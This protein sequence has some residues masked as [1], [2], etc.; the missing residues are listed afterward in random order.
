MVL[1]LVKWEIL[2]ITRSTAYARSLAVALLMLGLSI[3]LLS[4][5]VLMGLALEPILVQGLGKED[6]IGFLNSIL[7]Y[8]FLFEIIYR[9]FV[10]GL[11]VV[12]LES[13]LHLPISKSWIIRFLLIRSFI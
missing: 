9:Y 10:Q 6:P 2:K 12:E 13:L 5:V 4:Y 3:L 11:P 8:F 1:Q 7:I